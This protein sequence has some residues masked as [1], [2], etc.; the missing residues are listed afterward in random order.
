MK[1]EANS[2][3]KLA[4]V[5]AR[6]SGVCLASL[7]FIA[8]IAKGYFFAKDCNPSVPQ[9]AEFVPG[10][11]FVMTERASSLFLVPQVL[12]HCTRAQIL[13]LIIQSIPVFVVVISGFLEASTSGNFTVHQ[14]VFPS[15]TCPA[16]VIS[17][18][19]PK[20]VPLPLHEPVVVNGVNGGEFALRQW[21]EA[22]I[23]FHR[24]I[25]AGR[26]VFETPARFLLLKQATISSA[27][28]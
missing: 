23:C 10:D 20:S 16:S 4:E 2:K 7:S 8:K 28:K 17:V 18:L 9:T 12:N 27:S 24:L 11:S 3:S 25:R 21:D 1:L 6:S 13:A 22:S 15:S 14:D 26:F 5:L 19:S